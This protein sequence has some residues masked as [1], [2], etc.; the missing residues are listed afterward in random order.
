MRVAS[1][2]GGREESVVGPSVLWRGVAWWSGGFGRTA[3]GLR[4]LEEGL[5]DF[6]DAG[7]VHGGGCLSRGC[8]SMVLLENHARVRQIAAVAQLIAGGLRAADAMTF[9]CRR[10]QRA[11]LY[12]PWKAQ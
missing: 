6:F 5:L 1:R 7:F 4:A 3:P 11:R 9:P 12:L 8:L 2:E 10:I